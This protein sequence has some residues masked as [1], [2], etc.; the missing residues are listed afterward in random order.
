MVSPDQQAK[1]SVYRPIKA[2]DSYFILYD[3][4]G[5]GTFAFIVTPHIRINVT[6]HWALLEFEFIRERERNNII[7]GHLKSGAYSSDIPGTAKP[8]QNPHQ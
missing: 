8:N 1:R 4:I 3:M 2:W 7:H 6:Q 5:F